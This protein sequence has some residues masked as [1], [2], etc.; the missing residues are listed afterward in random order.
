MPARF[1]VGDYL[2]KFQE[3]DKCPP[4]TLIEDSNG[5][6]FFKFDE[7]PHRDTSV[8]LWRSCTHGFETFE[9]EASFPARVRYVPIHD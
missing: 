2:F 7:Y 5:H 4:D 9:E 6:Y 3:A 8:S 1:A